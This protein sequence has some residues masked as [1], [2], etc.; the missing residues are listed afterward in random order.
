MDLWLWWVRGKKLN[1]STHLSIL[2]LISLSREGC[3]ADMNQQGYGCCALSFKASVASMPQINSD[4]NVHLSSS[5]GFC[6]VHLHKDTNV[7]VGYFWHEIAMPYWR[8]MVMSSCNERGC[9]ALGQPASNVFPSDSLRLRR[10]GRVLHRLASIPAC[11]LPKFVQQK[12]DGEDLMNG[13]LHAGGMSWLLISP[14]SA[15]IK[16]MPQ[17]GQEAR[18]SGN[19]WSKMCTRLSTSQ[20]INEMNESQQLNCHVP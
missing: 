8:L 4:C 16:G 19:R 15:L 7:P 17:H 10:L 2:A 9:Q 20:R 5:N 3:R 11:H 14:S 13:L 12:L 1:W 18:L 6:P